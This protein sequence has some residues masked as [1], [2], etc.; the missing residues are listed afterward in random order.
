VRRILPV[1]SVPALF[2]VL[3]FF[4]G[5]CDHGHADGEN[6]AVQGDEHAGHEHGE[7]G[8]N[9]LAMSLD[10]IA[11]ARCE[12][13][14]ATYEC[15]ACRFEVGVVKVSD[16]L[17]KKTAS[18]GA[19]L[20]GTEVVALRHAAVRLDVTGEVRLNENTAVHISPR[21]PGIIESVQVDIGAR[22]VKG[23]LLLKINSVELGRMLADFERSNALTE[24]S[25]KNFERE[26]SL[27][28]RKISS[29]QDMIEAQMIHEGHRTELKAAKQALH[30][31]GLTEDDLAALREQINDT[32]M[33]CLPVRA[34]LAGTIIEKHAVIGELV[35]PGKSVML[36]ADLD[37]VWVWADIYE[38]D[39]HQLLAA[40]Q[41]DPIPVKVFVGAFPDR[42]FEGNVDYIG[43]TMQERTRTIKVRAT[44]H[45]TD[46]LLRPGMFCEIQIGMDAGE[47]V[48][49]VPKTALLADEGQH[50]V[51]KHWQDDLYVRRAVQK[52]REFFDT[53]EIT[54][55]L[56]P[57]ELVVTE[58]AFLL[59][60]DVLREKMGAGC[61]D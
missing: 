26:Q 55:G 10:E 14:I 22:V 51:F 42:L 52:G 8:E 48:L 53:V 27:M 19:G 41:E 9:P 35:E 38:Q 28:E 45:N 29:E 59:K 13:R 21:I 54:E 4:L 57:G 16:S 12:H 15:D 30:V 32:G 20:L 37:A 49:A 17:L 58:G 6:Q 25:R 11:A 23:D 50:F 47:D 31:F 40:E 3:V 43:A 1:S 60:S 39:L 24:L 56:E 2:A 33:G 34:P 18:A 7:E 46:R 61:A 5:A 36:L 44:V